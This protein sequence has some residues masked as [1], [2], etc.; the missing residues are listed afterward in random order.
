MIVRSQPCNSQHELVPLCTHAAC[1]SVGRQ[2]ASR[3]LSVE[4]PPR[5]CG[6]I[7]L[8]RRWAVAG[9]D[10]AVNARGSRSGRRQMMPVATDATSA[11]FPRAVCRRKALKGERGPTPLHPG[12]PPLGG[13]T[14][15]ASSTRRL[16]VCRIATPSPIPSPSSHPSLTHPSPSRLR[17]C[18]CIDAIACPHFSQRARRLASQEMTPPSSPNIISRHFNRAACLWQ[19]K[20]ASAPPCQSALICRVRDM[21]LCRTS[22][23]CFLGV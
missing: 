23:T 4:P 12:G 18:H 1:C 20:A 9:I 15:S 7:S 3:A 5:G 16:Q 21:S 22:T 8:R 14:S 11:D 10:A 17:R 19:L 6:R 2:A 13:P